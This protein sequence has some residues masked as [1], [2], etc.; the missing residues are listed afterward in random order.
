[1]NTRTTTPQASHDRAG[2]PRPAPISRGRGRLRAA[3]EQLPPETIEAIAQRVAELLREHDATT[4]GPQLVDAEQLAR[5][6][7]LSRAWVYQHAREL[8]AIRLGHGP[9]ARLRFNP[10]T[11]A[12]ALADPESS[13]RQPPTAPGPRGRPRRQPAPAAPL[14][15]ICGH[16]AIAGVPSRPARRKKQRG[17]LPWHAPQPDR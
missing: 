16:R 14:L 5:Q 7:G 1:M 13:P 6:L 12:S 8:G 11:A 10:A 3:V 17:I 4:A 15:P 2:Q 9:K